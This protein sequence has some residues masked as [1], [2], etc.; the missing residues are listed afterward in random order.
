MKS[1]SCICTQ[2]PKRPVS[3]WEDRVFLL[4]LMMPMLMRVLDTSMFSVA[5]PTIRQTFTIQT[6]VAGWVITS[7]S[8]PF[9]ISMPLYGGLGD[10]LGRRRLFLT[11]LTIFLIGTGITL[12]A[13][14]LRF[15]IVGRAIQGI[16]AAGIIPFCI[17]L[18]SDYF[19]DEK[20][21]KALGTWNSM[22]P[23]ATIT[24]PF[25]GGYLIDRFGWRAIFGPVLTVG[26]VSLF[27]VRKQVPATPRH[28][29]QSGL[30]RSF[31]WGGVLL[32]SPAISLLVFYASS[33]PIT[34]IDALQ[35]W[36]LLLAALLCLG[37]FVLWERRQRS[38][39]VALNVFTDKNFTLASL[40]AGIRMFAM[41]GIGFLIPLY[42]FDIHALGA[43]T[44]GL[45]I[46]LHAVALFVTMR[47][48]GQ[49]SDRWGS[50]WPVM[51]GSSMQAGTM[52]GIALLPEKGT[53][54][55]LVIGLFCH[56]L[57]AGLSAAALHHASMSRIAPDQRAMAAS[58]Y[59]MIR[60]GGT[61]FGAALGGVV[62]QYGLARSVSTIAA[63]Q[64]VFR[65]VAAVAFLGVA[66]G[67]ALREKD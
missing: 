26:L 24:G 8:L 33:R 36:R 1:D 21:G 27:A 18:I 5:L 67:W 47:M 55:W 15:L 38:P 40:G 43:S 59:S 63:Y 14:D 61:V 50:R 13:L 11:G 4:G 3:V 45:L 52:I 6:D 12:S 10:R 60:F 49:L 58:L 29:M 7:Y 31:D 37:G 19:P 30:L 16:G 32:L 17:T 39:F 9:I 41:E 28:L 54:G 66:S 25:V 48:G 46:T 56:G 42:L 53:L 44:I 23:L 51:I 2:G 34:G 62:L 22:G 57:G 20:R 65:F 35:D 64:S